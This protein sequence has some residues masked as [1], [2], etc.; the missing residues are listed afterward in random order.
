[1]LG[2]PH[3][4]IKP[5][6]HQTSPPNSHI[7][8]SSKKGTQLAACQAPLA[9]YPSRCNAATL[10]HSNHS[11]GTHIQVQWELSCLRYLSW[12]PPFEMQHRLSL[13]ELQ[14]DPCVLVHGGSPVQI[15]MWALLSEQ[16]TG[17]NWIIIIIISSS[18]SSWGLGS[19]TNAGYLMHS[20]GIWHSASHKAKV[21]ITFTWMHCWEWLPV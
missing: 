17:G 9:S 2:L 15:V 11:F 3:F 14:C 19:D 10:S 8:I 7:H 12:A 6:P 13:S 20:Y 4:Q 1:M 16:R 21:K 18:S 5:L